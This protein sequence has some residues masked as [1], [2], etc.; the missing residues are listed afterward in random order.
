MT[1]LLHKTWSDFVHFARHEVLNHLLTPGSNKIKNRQETLTE[2]ADKN[3]AAK[4]AS[5]NSTTN[6]S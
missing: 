1:V 2:K 5:V 4:T 6:S 3:K